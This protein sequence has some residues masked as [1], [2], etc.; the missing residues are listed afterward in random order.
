MSR[1]PALVAPEL[2][3][4]L[5]MTA[6]E[7]LDTAAAWEAEAHKYRLPPYS[8]CRRVCLVKADVWLR[9]ALTGGYEVP[10]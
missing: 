5:N 2:R 8:H 10:R 9:R 1:N 4:V 3:P 6:D 7:C